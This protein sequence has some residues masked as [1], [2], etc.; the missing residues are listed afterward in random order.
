[1]IILF[2]I[3]FSNYLKYEF[4]IVLIRTMNDSFEI[5]NEIFKINMINN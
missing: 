2:A 5:F 1:M 3:H 4:L